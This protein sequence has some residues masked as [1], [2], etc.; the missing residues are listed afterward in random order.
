MFAIIHGEKS[1]AVRYEV[2]ECVVAVSV[3]RSRERPLFQTNFVVTFDTAP[4]FWPERFWRE[5][6]CLSKLQLE[7]EEK[8]SCR[9]EKERSMY[10]A[11]SLP[12][13]S[14]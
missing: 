10:L 8:L 7:R 12:F 14:K 1:V 4:L 11:I 9:R 13:L 5:D 2:G 6:T 3:K